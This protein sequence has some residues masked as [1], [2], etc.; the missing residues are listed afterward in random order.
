MGRAKAVD[1]TLKLK[2]GFREVGI[3]LKNVL[4]LGSDGPNVNK[5]VEA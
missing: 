1:L 4:M 5:K 3:S 2:D